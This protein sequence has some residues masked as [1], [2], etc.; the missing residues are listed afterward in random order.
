VKKLK[1]SDF[2]PIIHLKNKKERDTRLFELEQKI[3][4]KSSLEDISAGRKQIV[5][6][7]NIY[8]GIS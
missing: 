1:F 5:L 3:S 7:G 8:N 2:Y 4:T 6:R